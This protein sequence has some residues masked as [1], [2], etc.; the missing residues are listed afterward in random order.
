MGNFNNWLKQRKN[1]FNEDV[2]QEF[3]FT[4]TA[5]PTV[6]QQGNPVPT[7][8]NQMPQNGQNAQTVQQTQVQQRG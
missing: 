3:G 1:S 6:P 4:P 2:L 5:P 7:Q 8:M